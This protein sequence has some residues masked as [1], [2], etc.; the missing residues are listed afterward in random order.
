MESVFFLQPQSFFQRVTV[1]LV[2]FEADVGFLDPVSGNCQRRVFR[3]N[4]LDTHDD[5]HRV[6][7][8]TWAS[9]EGSSANLNWF[10]SE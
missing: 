7:P 6:L 3:G 8:C 4:L 9:Q 10:V 1:W 5:F 2:H